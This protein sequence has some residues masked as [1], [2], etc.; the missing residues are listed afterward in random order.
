MPASSVIAVTHADDPLG[1]RVV[2]Q[3]GRDLGA[4]V[5]AVS[6][7]DIEAPDLKRSLDGVDVLV[8]VAAATPTPLEPARRVLA[9]ASDAG[10]EQ[11]LVV[12][13]ALVYGSW[14]SNPVPLTDDAP[15]RPNPDF[16][17]AVAFGEVERLVADW[18]DAHPS[19]VV[20][21]LRPTVPVAEGADGWL[22]PMLGAVRN[23]P[24]GEVDPPAQF[25]HLDDIASAVSVAITARLDGAANVAPDGWITG[26]E[27]RGLAGGPR[28][29]LPWGLG[30][31][32]TSWRWRAGLSPTPP[33]LLPWTVDPWVVASDRLKGLG[34]SA[35]HSN[36][37]AFVAAHPAT[38]WAMVSPRRRQELTLGI[39]AV[40]M[41]AGAAGAVLGLR[42]W[43]RGRAG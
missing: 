31:K 12:S 18:R 8:H 41:V 39:S 15:L 5:V 26:D 2:A 25:V 24:V 34:W 6:G 28:V 32:L 35:G 27:L 3:L 19:A 36:Q 30:A 7:D 14:P 22:A 40:A 9:A 17:P 16:E 10:V 4:R 21:V 1:S 11:L 37:E 23:V 29:R 13:T 20:A 38:P 43:R 42:R 33:G